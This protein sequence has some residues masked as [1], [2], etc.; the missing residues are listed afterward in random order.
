MM[1]FSFR[2]LIVIFMCL[3]FISSVASQSLQ[4]ELALMPSCSDDCRTRASVNIGCGP[5]NTT[6]QCQHQ[7]AVVGTIGQ[8]SPPSL[9]IIQACGNQNATSKLIRNQPTCYF[10]HLQLTIH[11]RSGTTCFQA[12]VQSYTVV[13]RNIYIR[14]LAK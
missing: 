13:A 10:Q 12:S 2:T 5:T 1:L 6:C 4:D 8:P 3:V 11:L 14:Q 9:C 7:N